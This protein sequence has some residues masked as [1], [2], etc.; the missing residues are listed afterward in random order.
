MKPIDRYSRLGIVLL[1]LFYLK[2]QLVVIRI[3]FKGFKVLY[4]K[5]GRFITISMGLQ[6]SPHSV[7]WDIYKYLATKSKIIKWRQ[8]RKV[9]QRSVPEQFLPQRKVP[10]NTGSRRHKVPKCKVPNYCDTRSHVLRSPITRS[11]D[12]KDLVRGESYMDFD[13]FPPC[14]LYGP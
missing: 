7:S 3:C 9:P 2:G 8:G 11:L 12:F 5:F 6:V 4:I 1:R 14:A 13:P 10:C